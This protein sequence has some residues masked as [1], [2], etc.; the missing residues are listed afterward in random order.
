MQ[1]CVICYL[2]PSQLPNIWV[3]KCSKPIWL[4]IR[5]HYD[6][7][8][9]QVAS[10]QWLKMLRCIFHHLVLLLATKLS[11]IT[12][13]TGW[14]ES[15]GPS[16][17]C[18]LNSASSIFCIIP[19]SQLSTFSWLQNQVWSCNAISPQCFS[20]S[21]WFLFIMEPLFRKDS[22]LLADAKRCFLQD[23]S[24]KIPTLVGKEYH[25]V[26]FCFVS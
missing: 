4:Q 9:Q 17:Y 23:L 24:Y 5:N 16:H 1:D 25:S 18:S 6:P 22:C 8:Q 10:R 2:F 12:A 21:N 26:S 11:I 19:D 20:N 13:E 3:A 14:N 15:P 7:G